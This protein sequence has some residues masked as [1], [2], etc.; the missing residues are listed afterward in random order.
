MTEKIGQRGHGADS[1]NLRCNEECLTSL[2][3][4]ATGVDVQELA[5][6]RSEIALAQ[7]VV[8]TITDRTGGKTVASARSSFGITAGR[9]RLRLCH[10]R[11]VTPYPVRGKKCFE[12]F[13]FRLKGLRDLCHPACS[14]ADASAWFYVQARVRQEA[15]AY[16]TTLVSREDV[17]PSTL[18]AS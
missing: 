16:V 3:V 1:T 8:E 6:Q 17:V 11:W 9:S 13:W 12:G 5:Y 2:G 7:G 4:R 14:R 18:P 15:D 10:T